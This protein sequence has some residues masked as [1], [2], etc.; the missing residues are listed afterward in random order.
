MLDK[1]IPI[2]IGVVVGSIITTA[3]S[4]YRDRKIYLANFSALMAEIDY[5]NKLAST[6]LDDKVKSPLYRLPTIIYKSSIPI[7]LAAGKLTN[8]ETES[9]LNFFNEVDSL[10]RGLDQIERY[11]SSS[12]ANETEQEFNRNKIKAGNIKSNHEA[13][14]NTCIK[15]IAK[16]A[17]CR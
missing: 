2:L 8:S 4:L 3:I 6:Y 14:V 11:R 16:R 5:C 1:A 9:I 10:N 15:H 7:I 13:A 17:S 12:D